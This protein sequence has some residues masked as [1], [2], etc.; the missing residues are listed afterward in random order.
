MDH[1][2]ALLV[3]SNHR[4]HGD[5]SLREALSCASR[6]ST[7][8]HHHHPFHFPHS[9]AIAA[10]H[11]GEANLR[12]F[13]CC[14][15]QSSSL[16]RR[17]Q[18]VRPGVARD[19]GRR[20]SRLAQMHPPLTTNLDISEKKNRKNDKSTN[21]TIRTMSCATRAHTRTH[22]P[23]YS[24]LTTLCKAFNNA[25]GCMLALLRSH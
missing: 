4:E 7:P 5:S 19:D 18:Q 11:R 22:T 1:T 13:H 20:G 14:R 23:S 9:L 25:V 8:L 15:T 12:T 2:T 17:H 24:T 16:W 3:V 21:H 6:K 10:G